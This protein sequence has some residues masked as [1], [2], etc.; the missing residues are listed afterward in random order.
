MDLKFSDELSN[1]FDYGADVCFDSDNSD[2]FPNE[3]SFNDNKK[4]D[5]YPVCSQIKSESSDNVKVTDREETPS[6]TNENNARHSP[7]NRLDED[8]IENNG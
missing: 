5:G 1:E 8:N 2:E 4:S 7:N 6:K 3:R